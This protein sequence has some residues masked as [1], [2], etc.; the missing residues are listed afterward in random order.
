MSA[1]NRWSYKKLLLKEIK[2]RILISEHESTG[3]KLTFHN[4]KCVVITEIL[5]PFVAMQ[6][7]NEKASN[8]NFI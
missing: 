4:F 7:F 8:H 1:K 5:Y 2:L 3:S 6:L